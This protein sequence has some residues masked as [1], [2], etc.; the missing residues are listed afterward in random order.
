MCRLGEALTDPAIQPPITA[1]VVYG[2][3]PM[4]ATPNAELIR[5]GLLRPD[6]FTVVH[7]QFITDTARY[8][9]ILL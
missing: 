4:V 8:A 7:E 2:A 9:D 5:T 3:N 1:L 6:L